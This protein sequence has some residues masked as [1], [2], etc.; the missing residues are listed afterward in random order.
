MHRLVQ[1]EQRGAQEHG[2]TEEEAQAYPVGRFLR[3]L[4]RHLPF[5]IS[6]T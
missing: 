5:E 3:V 1:I 4:R 6:V 2:G